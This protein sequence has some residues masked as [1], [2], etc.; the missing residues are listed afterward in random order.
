MPEFDKYA[1]QY[2]DL[3]SDPIRDRFAPGSNFFFER[4][5]ELL[6]GHCRASAWP[7]SGVDWLDVGCGRGDL[8]RIGAAQVRTAMGCDLSAEMLSACTDL[9]VRLQTEATRLPFPDGQFNLVTA[10]CV[11]HHVP[12][13]SRLQLTSEIF[14]MLRPRG[15]ACIVEHNPFNPATRLIV[16]R[17]PVDADARLLSAARARRLLAHAHFN[18]LRTNYFLYFP[19]RLYRK[20]RSLEALLGRVP[21]GGQYAVFGRKPGFEA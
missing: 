14:R 13:T 9:N 19:E 17:T 5:W 21:A 20:L 4:K 18:E 15:V 10:V 12:L 8:L 2:A 11:Y 6:V 3:L 16:H 1:D 7:L